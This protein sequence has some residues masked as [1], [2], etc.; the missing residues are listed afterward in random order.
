MTCAL[1]DTYNQADRW[2]PVPKSPSGQKVGTGMSWLLVL[3]LIVP[4]TLSTSSG[5]M[6][7]TEKATAA[8]S[9]SLLLLEQREQLDH[10]RLEHN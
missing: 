1:V 5:E 8:L 7:C 10:P 3:S 4:T 9:G 2:Q 6:T